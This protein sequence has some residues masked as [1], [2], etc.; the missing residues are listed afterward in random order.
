MREMRDA[1]VD[2]IATRQEVLR[3]ELAPDIREKCTGRTVS[4]K[5]MTCVRRANTTEELESCLL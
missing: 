3:Q 5:M 1:D 4:D 2:A